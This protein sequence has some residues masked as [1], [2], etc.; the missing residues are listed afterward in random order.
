MV[1]V[2]VVV[3]VAEVMAVGLR[4]DDVEEDEGASLLPCGTAEAFPG[5]E[6]QVWGEDG[7]HWPHWEEEP[8]GDQGDRGDQDDWGDQEDQG[9]QETFETGGRY[10]HV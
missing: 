4:R 7:G 3:V 6:E 2:V 1:V 9:D 8:W 10:I 5:E